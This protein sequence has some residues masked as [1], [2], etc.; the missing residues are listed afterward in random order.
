MLLLLVRLRGKDEMFGDDR[1][2]VEDQQMGW[3]CLGNIDDVE[4]R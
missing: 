4:I 1:E 3:V 2:L